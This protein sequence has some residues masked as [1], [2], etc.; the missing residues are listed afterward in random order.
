VRPLPHFDQL[1][2]LHDCCFERS[3]RKPSYPCT[4]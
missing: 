3:C 2:N 1:C 4:P